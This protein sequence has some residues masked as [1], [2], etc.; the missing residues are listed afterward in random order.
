[1]T[2]FERDIKTELQDGDEAVIEVVLDELITF[3]EFIGFSQTVLKEYADIMED[4]WNNLPW[5][6]DGC[7]SLFYEITVDKPI[8]FLGD[9]R[10]VD[11][12]EMYWT[13]YNYSDLMEDYHKHNEEDEEATTIEG[14]EDLPK[15]LETIDSALKEEL[16]ELDA[17]IEEQYENIES[18]LAE[19]KARDILIEMLL[20][21]LLST[22][23]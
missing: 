10:D 4:W 13:T 22:R 17:Q 21:K 5:E 16:A 14:D 2:K 12:S 11:I 1:M 23:R 20:D 3:S 8:R 15:S 6:A 9:G 7:I 19:V 18:L